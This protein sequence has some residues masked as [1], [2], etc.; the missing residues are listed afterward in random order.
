[1]S[2]PTLAVIGRVVGWSEGVGEAVGAG[3]LSLEGER[4]RFTHPLLASVAY[5]A[6]SA[7]ERRGAHR[8][9][10]GVV[11]G[12]ERAFQL[13]LASEGPDE[14]T[15]SE[16]EAA[17]DQAL[18]RGARRAA[19][20]LAEHALR[21]T[22]GESPSLARRTLA[23]AERRLIAGDVGRSREL[24][25]QALA[26]AKPGRERAVVL[27]PLSTSYY[28]ADRIPAAIDML[29]EAFDQAADD[30]ELR[31]RI[32][33]ARA[34]LLSLG[35]DIPGSIQS[36]HRAVELAEQL[37][38]PGLL[39]LAM[40]RVAA[41]EF[42]AGLAYDRGRLEQAVALEE[43][44]GEVP[45]EWLPSFVQATNAGFADDYKTAR[46]VFER[47]HRPALE[48][49]GELA[50]PL[51]LFQSQFELRAGNWSLADRLS[52]EAIDLSLLD[53]PAAARAF[54]LGLRAHVAAHLG[55]VEEARRRAGEALHIARDNGSAAPLATGMAALGFL[56]LSLGNPAAAH[57]HL[58]PLAEMMLAMGVGEPN[59]LRFLPDEIEALVALGELERARTAL[60]ALEARALAVE[61]WSMIA[62][63]CRCRGLVAATSG[64][65]DAAGQTLEEALEHHNRLAQPFELGRTL[66]V[67][68]TIERR[69]RQRGAARE[70][71]RR[72]LEIFDG[73]GAPLWAEK[74]A[75]ELA[76]IPGRSACADGLTPTERRVAELV[77]EGLSNKEVAAALFITVRTVEANLT[78]VYGKL[79]VHSRAAIARR[80]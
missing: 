79:G 41:N 50:L 62:A 3:V 63:A 72:A 26:T 34:F 36:A 24:L 73:L 77:A 53:A 23:A 17:A 78:R 7:D 32:E 12:D 37:G 19:A 1:M 74:A 14:G 18:R 70:S 8:R 71:L 57:D 29:G 75:A 64:D 55:R 76:R 21:L 33:Q 20:E 31:V 47:L 60:E 80:L 46:S 10:V 5:G 69:A 45:V 39:A 27:L 6:V 49:L 56:E 44:V 11:E 67:K 54:A 16:L 2:A 52:Q 61:R 59:I 22:P 58:G 51:L 4:V 48:R 35:G 65:L 28:M 13:A 30:L 40:A 43:H 15:A 66:L 68:G 25:E 38:D 9:L 42:T